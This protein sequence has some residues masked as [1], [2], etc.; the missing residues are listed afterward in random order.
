[1]IRTDLAVSFLFYTAASRLC[2]E[3]VQPLSDGLAQNFCSDIHDSQSKDFGG[4]QTFPLAPPSGQIFN[5][6]NTLF[7]DYI[8][9]KL[10]ASAVLCL[11]FIS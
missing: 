3:I 10:S 9:A 1:M 4:P 5:S 2:Y 11:V 6:P 8:P 7:Y